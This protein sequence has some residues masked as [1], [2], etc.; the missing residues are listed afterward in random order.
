MWSRR[1]GGCW[2]RPSRRRGGPGTMRRH[3]RGSRGRRWASCGC[4]EGTGSIRYGGCRKT[5]ACGRRSG[6][7]AGYEDD[8]QKKRE[9]HEPEAKVAHATIPCAVQMEPPLLIGSSQQRW[10]V[11]GQREARAIEGV[12]LSQSPV[13]SVPFAATP[14]AW[15]VNRMALRSPNASSHSHLLAGAGNRGEGVA[16]S[17]RRVSALD[18]APFPTYSTVGAN[19]QSGAATSTKVCS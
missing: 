19:C 7:I 10:P 4:W 18:S 2:R 1:K 11:M 17:R 15:T 14:L 8:W 3:R 13:R 16:W 9:C 5:D 12:S 6:S